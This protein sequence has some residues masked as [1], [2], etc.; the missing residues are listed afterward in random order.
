MTKSHWP[1]PVLALSLFLQPSSFP[2][3]NLYF[4]CTTKL[5]TSKHIPFL[6]DTSVES[7]F[8]F[9]QCLSLWTWSLAV[10]SRLLGRAAPGVLPPA[11]GEAP[12]QHSELLYLLS[13]PPSHHP[14][15]LPP[16]FS[17]DYSVASLTSKSCAITPVPAHFACL[18]F[19]LCFLKFVLC[20][21]NS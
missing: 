13:F 5:Q 7:I 4:W 19:C 9:L 10:S 6:S 8:E 3:I 12:P 15:I 16:V 18:L 21:W 14:T 2:S 17:R 20:I 11:F 1:C